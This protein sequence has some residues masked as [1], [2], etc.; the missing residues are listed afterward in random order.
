[1]AHDKFFAICE[2]KCLVDITH[3]EHAEGQYTGNG[4]ATERN[5]EVGGSGNMLLITSANGMVIVTSYGGIGKAQA[6]TTVTGLTW[7]DIM[8]IPE[9]NR[10]KIKSTNKLINTFGGVYYWRRM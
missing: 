4:E 3:L 5:I 8:F 10:L 6:D 1:M 7:T 2:N 9:E